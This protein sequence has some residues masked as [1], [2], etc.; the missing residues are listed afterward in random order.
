MPTK[1]SDFFKMMPKLSTTKELKSNEFQ[2]IKASINL[3]NCKPVEIKTISCEFCNKNLK[4]NSSLVLHKK[5]LH[6]DKVRFENCKFCD[7][8]FMAKKS[9][10]RHTKKYH[11]NGLMQKFECDFDGKFFKNKSF[12]MKHMEVH[13]PK[14]E[15]EI[16]HIFLRKA[17]LNNHIATHNGTGQEYKCDFCSKCF[18]TKSSLKSHRQLHIKKFECEI[19]NKMF[20]HLQQVRKHKKEFHENPGSFECSIC[21]KI[22]NAKGGLKAHEIIHDKFAP[23]HLKCQKCN[24]KTNSKRNFEQHQNVHQRKEMKFAAMKNPLKCDKCFIFCSTPMKLRHHVINSHPLNPFQCDLCGR[25]LK[26]KIYL[27]NHMK[28][29]VNKK[30]KSC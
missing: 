14:V 7:R 11:S 25:Y 12:L 1:I 23:K 28:I 24:Y 6:S 3:E 29:C 21:G 5:H 13:V 10:E 16:C 4:N 8:K 22:F 18:R 15:C 9:L 27:K 17:N 2:N 30:I 26:K 20:S 19:C